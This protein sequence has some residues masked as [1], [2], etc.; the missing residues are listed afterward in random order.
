[1]P[2]LFTATV[3]RIDNHPDFSLSD[4]AGE[5]TFRF[6]GH[7]MRAR[8][9]ETIASALF[10]NGV[11]LFS[12]SFKYHRPRGLYDCQGQG[13][14]TLVTVDHTPNQLADRVVVEEGMD[15]RTQNAWPSVHFDLMA[16]ANFLVPLL[17]N[18]FYY[19]M[20][21]KPRWAWP[22]FEKMHRPAAGWGKIDTTGREVHSS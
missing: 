5:L 22:F 7:R 8:K 3:T 6:Q 12:R 16:P 2:K 19:K 4:P 14:E 15:V 18:V 11:K 13:P 10:A 21:H 17:P 20:F 1:M 9:G